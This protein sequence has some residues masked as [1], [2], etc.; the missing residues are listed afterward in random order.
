[1][2]NLLD[3]IKESHEG[4]EPRVFVVDVQAVL[5]RV[6]RPGQDDGAAVT[7]IAERAGVS[8]RTVY[9][10]LNPEEGKETIS[11]DLADRLCNACGDHISFSC[12]LKMAD[13]TI[14]RPLAVEG[15]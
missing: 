6:I 2:P 14:I 9:R 7:M 4:P 10:V 1:V 3:G 8:T 5:R 13:G 15:L 11:L 12:S